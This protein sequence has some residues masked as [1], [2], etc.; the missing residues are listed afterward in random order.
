MNDNLYENIVA[1]GGFE[2]WDLAEDNS[3]MTK[4]FHFNTFEQA[5]AFVQCVGTVAE[6]K[7][8]HPEWSTAN[9]GK[10]LVVRLTSHF[11]NN[12]VTRNDFEMGEAMN[13]QERY[14]LASFKQFP[15]YSAAQ[16]ASFQIAFACFVLGTVSFKIIS[17]PNHATR[18][19]AVESYGALDSHLIH[20]SVVPL[21]VN[22]IHTA[23]EI[24][25]FVEE[26]LESYS[27]LQMHGS[28]HK[29][30]TSKI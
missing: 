9:G 29:L 25:K 26:N 5:N 21:E 14:V 8:H 4:S 2:G 15:K 22:N 13:E 27:Y 1:R 24:E 6:K 19:E 30:R 3:V 10:T 28:G 18:P 12:T 7:D 16:W 23:S 17:G 20:T 11:A